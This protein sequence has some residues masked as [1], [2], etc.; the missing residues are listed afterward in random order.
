MELRSYEID[1]LMEGL[2]TTKIGAVK[3]NVP[4][5]SIQST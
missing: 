2:R 3:L 1:L 4:F 5:E